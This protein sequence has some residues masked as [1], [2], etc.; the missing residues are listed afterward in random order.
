MKVKYTC[1]DCKQE[2]QEKDNK[3]SNMTRCKCGGRAF[4]NDRIKIR[5]I[6]TPF[7]NRYDNNR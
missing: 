3:F 4:K 5:R 1:E 6:M 7:N 2:F